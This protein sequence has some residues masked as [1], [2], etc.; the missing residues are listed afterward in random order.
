MFRKHLASLTS[1]L[2][3][4]FPSF[5]LSKMKRLTL[6]LKSEK[7]NC[8]PPP[9]STHVLTS[10][11]VHW[12]HPEWGRTTG[13]V[14]P[15]DRKAQGLTKELTG[16]WDRLKGGVT[17]DK[18]GCDCRPSLHNQSYGDLNEENFS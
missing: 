2:T 9:A 12:Y 8:S 15:R 1:L 10:H 14:E 16:K 13:A 4:F 17:E 7:N 6:K 5:L 3:Y 18:P 11:T